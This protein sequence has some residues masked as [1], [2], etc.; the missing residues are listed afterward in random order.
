[1][2]TGL[3]LPQTAG[4]PQGTID[5]LKTECAPLLNAKLRYRISS[6]KQGTQLPFG[7]VGATQV[8]DVLKLAEIYEP[9]YSFQT[10]DCSM[11]DKVCAQVTVRRTLP[12]GTSAQLPTTCANT[13]DEKGQSVKRCIRTCDD[14]LSCGQ[15]FQCQPSRYGDMRCMYA[16]LSD[17]LFAD[18][19]P[20][21]QAYQIR[22]GDAFLVTGQATG[23]LSDLEPSATDRECSLPVNATAPF[24]KLRQARLPLDPAKMDACDPSITRETAWL[25]QPSSATRNVC[26]I[27]DDDLETVIHFE[28]PWFAFGLAVPK[29]QNGTQKIIIPPP[30]LQL[31]FQVVG[32]QGPL[33]IALA[34]DVQ[35]Q[36]PRVAITGP[37]RQTVYIVDEGKQST[38]TGLRGQLLRLVSGAQ[39]VDRTF[40]VR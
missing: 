30:S 38:G 15:D 16:P 36:Q 31:S 17:Q 8:T 7:N 20:E 9:E 2:T 13:L 33:V 4:R 12:D 34:T 3:C 29:I 10:L 39:S 25:A 6:A 37:D 19:L 28:N 5:A 21:L 22:A 23:Q 32:G 40:Q 35:A 18:C 26:K 24:V 1:V 11:D 27:L 14:G